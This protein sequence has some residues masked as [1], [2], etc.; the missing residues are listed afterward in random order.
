[1]SKKNSE[2]C[3]SILFK[4]T[5]LMT[6]LAI[7]VIGGI[8][9]AYQK[10]N[11]FFNRGGT[12]VVPD[13]R[14]KHIVEVFKTKPAGLDIVR[15]DEKFDDQQ[16]KD[17]VIAQYPEPGTL[18]KQGKKIQLS[19]SLGVQ[20]VMVPDLKGNSMRE[21]DLA[22][23]NS[24]LVPGDRAYVHSDE[25]PHDKIVGQSPMPSEEYGVNKQ[26]DLL[27][28]LG[29]RPE[30]YVLPNLVGSSLDEGKTKLKAWG[31][32]FGRIYSRKDSS[33]P[34]FQ[35]ISTSPSPYSRVKKGEVVSLLVSAGDD[36]GTAKAED[37]KKF[38]IFSGAA[39]T[40]VSVSDQPDRPVETAAPPRILIA[41]DAGSPAIDPDVPAV[42]LQPSSMA[43]KEISFVM[44]DG[45]MPKEVKFIHI[46]NDGR[47]QIYAGTHKPLDLV[48]VKVPHVPNS[49]IQIYINDVP[50]EE[51]RID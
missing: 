31:F 14:G 5:I 26:V 28:S 42:D 21:V 40:S 9:F 50:I 12:I 30:S 51:R 7:V 47:Q 45:F 33:R 38:E 1:M 15:R 39:A 17:H 20:K 24:Q 36:E 18:V 27:I 48:K 41:E 13:F 32:N 37:L 4:M 35:I 3:I 46:T 29:R 22:L 8:F 23:L 11:E 10:L 43:Q 34:K 49:K 2:S 19:I 25:I 44:P 6:I 16:P